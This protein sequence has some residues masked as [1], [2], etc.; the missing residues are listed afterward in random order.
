M[1]KGG[2]ADP[3]MNG[4]IYG[5]I[6]IPKS[7]TGSIWVLMPLCHPVCKTHRD[8]EIATPATLPIFSD[9]YQTYIRFVKEI[10]TEVLCWMIRAIKN[11]TTEYGALPQQPAESI[12][13][14][15]QSTP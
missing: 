3:D 8:K 2:F 5:P 15:M 13:W 10:R 1:K 4:I 6:Y 9:C 11:G 14:E 7:M 12:S